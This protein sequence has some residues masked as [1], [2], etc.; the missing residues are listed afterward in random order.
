MSHDTRVKFPKLCCHKPSGRAYVMARGA[1]GSR[2]AV[3]LGRWGTPEA[4]AEWVPAS[5]R[6]C[7]SPWPGGADIK[8]RCGSWLTVTAPVH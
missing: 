3:Y 8:P 1:D 2:K 6:R 5:L 4:S 7:Y